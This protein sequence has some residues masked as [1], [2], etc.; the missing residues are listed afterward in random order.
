MF[1]KLCQSITFE[2]IDSGFKMNFKLQI[3]TVP[4]HNGLAPPVGDIPHR[5][6]RKFYPVSF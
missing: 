3:D 2:S 4:R 1:R 6:R 5:T